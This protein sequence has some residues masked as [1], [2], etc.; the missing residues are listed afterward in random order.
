MSDVNKALVR[1]YYDQV[2]NGRD[3]DA[4]EEYFADE[5]RVEGVRRG[6]FAYFTGFPDLHIA[7][8]EMIAEG[9][10]VFVPTTM[11]GTHDGEIKGIPATGR[12]VAVESA[13][14]YTIAHGKFAG[15]WCQA[16]VAGMLRQLTE[17]KVVEATPA[18][19]S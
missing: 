5:R 1:R 14:V 13:E 15:Y 10:K 9:D 17:E 3:L 4:V 6:C 8:D 19:A 12:H 16:D 7:I 18:A 2:L 11:T